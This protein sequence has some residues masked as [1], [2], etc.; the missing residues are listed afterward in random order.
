MQPRSLIYQG[1]AV[2]V[3]CSVV[4]LAAAARPF[5]RVP[6]APEPYSLAAFFLF[7][8][9]LPSLAFSFL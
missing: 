7:S 6:F 2:G 1:P 4:A 8:L 3:L 9:L 5:V